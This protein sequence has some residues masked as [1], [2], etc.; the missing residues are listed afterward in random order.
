MRKDLILLI[1]PIL[2]FSTG[3]FMISRP[4]LSTIANS[5]YSSATVFVQQDETPT[6]SDCAPGNADC[7]SIESIDEQENTQEPAENSEVT[8]KA[9]TITCTPESYVESDIQVPPDDT[10]AMIKAIEEANADPELSVICLTESTYYL[11]EADNDSGGSPTGLPPITSEI[12]IFGNN[13]IISRNSDDVFRIIYIGEGGILTLNKITIDNG[14]LE[15]EANGAGIFVDSGELY[16]SESTLSRNDNFGDDDPDTNDHYG[17]AIAQTGGEMTISNSL[18]I[19]NRA[20]FGGAISIRTRRGDVSTII[21]SSMFED[22]LAVSPLDTDNTNGGAIIIHRVS[23]SGSIEIVDSVFSGNAA[24]RG[25]AIYMSHNRGENTPTISVDGLIFEGNIS[26]E[27]G[28]LIRSQMSGDGNRLTV[29]SLTIIDNNSEP[30]CG[31]DNNTD[32]RYSPSGE[33]TGGDGTC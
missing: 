8:P 18:F 17:G 22:N 23:P 10:A 13:A 5:E 33:I 11:T 25:A 1:C 4:V 30:L 9:D 32:V 20:R 19:D 16:M 26:V 7:R 15:G 27:P 29:G 14:R 3:D 31:Y 6:K 24:K 28:S 12:M 21:E 2:I